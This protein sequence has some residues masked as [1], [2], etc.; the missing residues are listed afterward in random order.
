MGDVRYVL[1]AVIRDPPE[2][3][4]A[5]LMLFLELTPHQG[6]LALDMPRSAMSGN[7]RVISQLTSSYHKRITGVKS[8]D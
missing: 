1:C 8:G 2:D 3:L 4:Q 5:S 6:A 7:M